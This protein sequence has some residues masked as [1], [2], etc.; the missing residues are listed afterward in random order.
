MMPNDG[1]GSSRGLLFHRCLI[2][3]YI[4]NTVNILHFYL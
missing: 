1:V 2:I 3:D 4:V